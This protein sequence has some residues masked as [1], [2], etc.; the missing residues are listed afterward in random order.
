[1]KISTS[2]ETFDYLNTTKFMPNVTSAEITSPNYP[3]SY[4]I[5]SDFLW[6]VTAVE[7]FGLKLR[8]LFIDVALG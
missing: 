3:N 7:G 5:P 6:H 2:I 8:F 1:M 4:P